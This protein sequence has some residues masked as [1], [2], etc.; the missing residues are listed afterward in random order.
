V[1]HDDGETRDDSPV[2]PGKP[3]IRRHRE[4]SLLEPILRRIE[5]AAAF[6]GGLAARPRERGQPQLDDD[7]VH[8]RRRGGR[9][10]H[11]EKKDDPE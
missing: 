5:D 1:R 6:D 10:R 7:L 8:R 2:A 11:G 3:G 4:D 9:G